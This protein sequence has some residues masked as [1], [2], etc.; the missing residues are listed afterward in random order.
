MGFNKRFISKE[1]VLSYIQNNKPVEN[2][3][4][5]DAIFMDEWSSI[6][7][8]DF[9]NKINYNEFRNRIV[10]EHLFSSNL[11]NLRKNELYNSLKSVSN[12]YANLIYDPNW[13]DICLTI[14]IFN[15]KIDDL[16]SGD[17]GKL[18]KISKKTIEEYF[19]SKCRDLKISS[20]TQ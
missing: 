2:L 20:I 5:A 8:K 12:I 11:D 4:K 15:I 13:I 16:D 9:N 7:F 3:L 10:F 14:D 19:T 6:F 18:L 17:F 1:T